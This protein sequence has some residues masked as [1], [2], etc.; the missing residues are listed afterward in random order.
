MKQTQGQSTRLYTFLEKCMM[1]WQ[2]VI[3]SLIDPAAGCKSV[4]LHL[5]LRVAVLFE[6]LLRCWCWQLFTQQQYQSTRWP[7]MRFQQMQRASSQGASAHCGKQKPLSHSRALQGS[8]RRPPSSTMR[9]IRRPACS[10]KSKHHIACG[11]NRH[12]RRWT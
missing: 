3:R 1:Y 5:M 6:F 7:D 8:Q 11:H 9:G 12:G 2:H 4:L 10:Y